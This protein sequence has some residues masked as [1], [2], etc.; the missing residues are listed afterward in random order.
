MFEYDYRTVRYPEP[1]GEIVFEMNNVR[2]S[3]SWRPDRTESLAQKY[4]AKRAYHRGDGSF[5]T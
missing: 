5:W 3:P 1:S 2:S 4:S